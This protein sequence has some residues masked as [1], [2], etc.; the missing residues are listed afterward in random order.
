MQTSRLYPTSLEALIDVARMWVARLAA[1]FLRSGV[2]DPAQSQ[3][4]AL[5]TI[6]RLARD[7][8]SIIAQGDSLALIGAALVLMLGVALYLVHAPHLGAGI[9]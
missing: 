1:Y 3:R 9:R 4:A 7:E 2:A 8:A 5:A 6:G